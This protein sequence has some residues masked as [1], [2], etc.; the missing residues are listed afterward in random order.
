MMNIVC[1]VGSPHGVEGNTARLMEHVLQGAKSRGALCEVIS[2]AQKQVGFCCG[3]DTCHRSGRCPHG[4]D[5]EE[6]REKIEAADGV[7]LAS[8]NYIFSVSAQ[9]KAFMD[10]CCGVVHCMSFRGKYGLAVVTSGGG[11]DEPI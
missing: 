5:F 10:R 7:I 8:P 2:L 4:D 11:G 3:C 9:M 6:I 1:V